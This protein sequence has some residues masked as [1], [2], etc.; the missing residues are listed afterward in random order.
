QRIWAFSSLYVFGDGVCTTT[1]NASG[2]NYFYGNR[3][4]NG[5]V[6]V[7]VLAQWQG[8]AYDSAKNK[9]FFGN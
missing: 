9:S 6:W 1:D 5:R 8:L 2:A 3:Y 4:C 7:E